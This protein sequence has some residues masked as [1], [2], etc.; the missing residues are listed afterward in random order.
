MWAPNSVLLS[1]GVRGLDGT[2]SKWV[3]Y[4]ALC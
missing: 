1:S 4:A 2:L 3:V